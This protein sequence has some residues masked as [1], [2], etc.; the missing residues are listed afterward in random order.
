M[1]N[2]KQAPSANGVER[3]EAVKAVETL[4]RYIGEN[5]ER[6]GLQ[7]TPDRFC[8]ALLELTRGYN[9]DPKEILATTFESDAD[10]MIVLRDIEFTSTCEH[11]LLPFSGKA[12]VAYLPEKGKIVGLSKLA[13]IIDVYSQRLQVQER[14]THQVATA[15]QNHLNPRGVAVVFEGVHSCMCVR[16]VRK[17]NATMSTSSMT[18]IF[19]DSSTIRNEFL[20]TIK[21]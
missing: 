10:E 20:A 11:H 8:R 9:E 7:E 4:L 19:K 14:L 21:L 17:Q 2:H 6:E 13:R 1:N 15:I 18:G 16:G 3:F 12:H 5:P